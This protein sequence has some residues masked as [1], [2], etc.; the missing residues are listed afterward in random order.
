MG[1][2][3]KASTFLEKGQPRKA[4]ALLKGAQKDAQALF[5]RAEAHRLVG[6]FTEAIEDYGHAAD[7]A[8]EDLELLCDILIGHAAC[9]RTIG[10]SAPAL[11][12][13]NRAFEIARKH[14]F[15]ELKTSARL[16]RALALRARGELN[17]SLAELNDL[18]KLF[19]R[20]RE[21]DSIGFIKWA[22]GGI[23]RL[24]GKFSLGADEFRDAVKLARKT[25]DKSAEGYAI[26]G[27]AGIVRVGGDIASSEKYY[28]EASRI[29]GDTSDTFAR[30]Y[31]HCGLANA[32]R[33][34]GKYDEAYNNYLKADKLYSAIKDEPDLGF[35]KWGIANI[36]LKRGK[37]KEALHQ[38]ELAR[39]LFAKYD[40]KRGEVLSLL[41][42]AS[43]EYLLGNTARAARDY[44]A[45]VNEARQN[46]LY[47]YLENFT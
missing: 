5:I 46:G 15:E 3:E 45:A 16:E 4:L 13:A 1:K 41:S 7:H 38:F 39:D 23:Y 10:K 30:A 47:T 21:L 32:L 43:V 29:F 24:Q 9:L 8:G 14:G 31:A 28:R 36:L 6:L 37:L 44:D 34:G 26:F 17:K 20:R 42:I 22:R 11:K 12:L 25:G 27:L 33:Q 19:T 2:I 35:V 18:L 40:E